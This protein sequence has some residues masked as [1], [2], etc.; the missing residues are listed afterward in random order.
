M[1]K[2]R[3]FPAESKINS[4]KGMLLKYKFFSSPLIELTQEEAN[5]LEILPSCFRDNIK[6]RRNA[7]NLFIDNT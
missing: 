1:Q 5:V 2:Y 7:T 4:N 6:Q 3:T